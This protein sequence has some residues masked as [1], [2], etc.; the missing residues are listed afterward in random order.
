MKFLKLIETRFADPITAIDLSN[1][2]VCHGSA[3]GRIAFYDIHENKD[4][5]LSDSQP[6]LV[7]GIS[8][9]EKGD[10]IYI[11]IG[12]ISCQKLN[13][14][15]LQVVD[16]VIIVSV[17]DDRQHKPQCEKAFTLLHGHQN[18]VLNMNIKKDKNQE[19]QEFKQAPICLS[20][21]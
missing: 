3:M 12:D 18:C 11:S 8:H 6:E 21:L 15:D 1:K 16:N 7:R 19:N 2:F 10:F 17:T 5:V 14:D 20:N 13:A 4:L 9:D